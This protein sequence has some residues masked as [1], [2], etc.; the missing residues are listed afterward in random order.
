MLG[1]LELLNKCKNDE[2]IKMLAEELI[3]YFSK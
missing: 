1:L 2:D 3:E